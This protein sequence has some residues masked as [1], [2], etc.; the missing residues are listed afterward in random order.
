LFFFF[1][2]D[3]FRQFFFEC[4]QR[5]PAGSAHVIRI[6][7]LEYLEQLCPCDTV[8][9]ESRSENSAQTCF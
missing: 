3:S 8:G 6:P 7:C 4:V 5:I 9:K 1:Q 2:P